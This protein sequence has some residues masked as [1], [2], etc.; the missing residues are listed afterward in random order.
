MATDFDTSKLYL[1]PIG[2]TINTNAASDNA[3]QLSAEQ[4]ASIS[5][6]HLDILKQTG[7]LNDTETYNRFSNPASGTQ[8]GTGLVTPADAQAS[9]AKGNADQAAITAQNAAMGNPYA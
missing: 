3:T 1:N 7:S 5:P 6:A 8:V 9:I 4:M 2:R